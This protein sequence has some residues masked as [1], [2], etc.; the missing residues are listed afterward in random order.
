MNCSIIPPLKD[1][2]IETLDH[3]Y[4]E[5]VMKGLEEFKEGESQAA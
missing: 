2:V 3:E 1:I 5:R 4:K